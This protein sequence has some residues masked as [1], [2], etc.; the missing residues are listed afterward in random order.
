[1]HPKTGCN[2]AFASHCW[3]NLETQLRKKQVLLSLAAPKNLGGPHLKMW[4]DFLDL[5]ASGPIIWRKEIFEGI[6]K[7]GKVL[8]FLDKE[9]LLRCEPMNASTKVNEYAWE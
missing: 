8:V 7:A 6:E 2:D 3:R 4:C 5:Q 1:M 9:Y